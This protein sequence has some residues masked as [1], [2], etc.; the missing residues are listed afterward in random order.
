MQTC[1]MYVIAINAPLLILGGGMILGGGRRGPGL[2]HIYRE[3]IQLG[4]RTVPR[5]SAIFWLHIHTEGA[6][7][8]IFSTP[9][10]L[11]MNNT[12]IHG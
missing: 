7:F 4:K 10:S 3:T 6:C 9:K 11:T 12:Q 8:S 1:S 5:A 2:E